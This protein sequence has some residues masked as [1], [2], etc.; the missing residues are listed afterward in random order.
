M[1]KRIVLFLLLFSGQMSFAVSYKSENGYT[2]DAPEACDRSV[3][4]VF[5]IGECL[6][7]SRL[8]NVNIM[9]QALP[10]GMTS[11]SYL[12]LSKK[13]YEEMLASKVE[14]S[15][16]KI[17]DLHAKKF[18][19]SIGIVKLLQVV[20][21]KDVTAY[22]FTYTASIDKFETNLPQVEKMLASWRF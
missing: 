11:E 4:D 6:N 1:K 8:S 17:C 20:L 10:V 13:Q 7:G 19:V 2:I 12:E 14:V 22:V 21:I 15:D 5:Q 16:I 9:K 18:L 3:I